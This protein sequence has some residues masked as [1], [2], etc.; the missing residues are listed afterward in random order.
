MKNQV[1]T[2]LLLGV[3]SALLI[4]F[5]AILGRTWML[6]FAALAIVMNVGAYYFSDRIVLRMHN[7]K[8]V[9]EMEAPRLYAM[10]RELSV[11]AQI[12]VPRLYVIEANEPNAFATGR[13]P[14]NAVVAVTTG[15]VRILDERE[16]RGVIAHEL[17][18]V[19]NRD[20]LVATIA[21]AVAA[22]IS[23]IANVLQFT[24]IF[25]GGDSEEGPS[26]LAMI[27]LALVAPIAAT[28]I[29]LGVSRSREYLADETGAKISGDPEALASALSKLEIANRGGALLSAEPATASLYIVNPLSGVEG[30]TSLFSTHPPIRERVH[31]LRVLAGYPESYAA[32]GRAA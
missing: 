17:A 25:G 7:A 31:R 27:G 5:G 26:P 16:L 8:P 2:I 29:Q 20:I 18:H 22:A 11:R 4:G 13:N 3:L 10:V 19:K 12:P 1:K 9:T 15:I 21:A 30:I 24:A 32:R 14:E 6:A 23:M 28:L